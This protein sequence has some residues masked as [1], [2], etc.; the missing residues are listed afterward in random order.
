MSHANT[1]MFQDVAII[2]KKFSPSI[3]LEHHGTSIHERWYVLAAIEMEAGNT[4]DQP[5][6]S[7]ARPLKKAG[8]L[9]TLHGPD[10]FGKS[11][12]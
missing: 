3:V 8:R 4:A 10:V 1:L 11:H 9:P 5:E 6:V 12:A 2:A 7:I